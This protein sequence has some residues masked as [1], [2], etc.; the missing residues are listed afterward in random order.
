MIS[1]SK[2]RTIA[3]L[4]VGF[5]LSVRLKSCSCRIVSSLSLSVLRMKLYVICSKNDLI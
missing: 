4:E 3:H 1:Y 2:Y 5:L